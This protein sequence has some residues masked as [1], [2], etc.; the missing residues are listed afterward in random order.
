MR[1]SDIAARYGAWNSPS[2]S[3]VS[4]RPAASGVAERIR[5]RTGTT[6][7]TL[8]PGQ[9]GRLTVSIGVA[10]AQNDWAARGRVEAN[11]RH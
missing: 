8:G 2:I 10:V 1:E 9:T 4:M 6:I 5:E 7:I 3:T 11:A